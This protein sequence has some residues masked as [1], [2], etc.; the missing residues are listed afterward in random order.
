M[1]KS[2][3]LL[4]CFRRPGA[5]A[6]AQLDALSQSQAV[7]EFLPDGTI[8]HANEY[9]LNAMGYDLQDLVGRHHSILVTPLERASA[10]YQAF[11]RRL[12]KGN[13]DSGQ[14]K[15]IG[16]D[17]REVWIQ[18]TYN[19]IIDR[20]GRVAR[21]VKYGADIT[22]EKMRQADMEGQIAAI[23][24]SQAVIEFSLDGIILY[25]NE[26]FLQAMGYEYDE[27]VGRH[28]SMFVEAGERESAD[29]KEFW[30]KL[31]AGNFDANV[32]RRV[33]KNAREV[34][35][36][37]TYNP[38]LDMNG[39]PFKVVKYATD[40]TRQVQSTQTLA[41]VVQEMAQV[42]Q[43][44]ATQANE[45]HGLTREAADSADLGG[46]NVAAL[47]KRMTE[48]TEA[49]SRISEITTLLD[50]IAFQT[51][52]LALN[53]AIEAARAGQAGRGF[54]VVAGEVRALA[55]RSAESAKAIATLISD[56]VEQISSGEAQ[57]RSVGETMQQLTTSVQAV[58][59]LMTQ[60]ADSA[61]AQTEGVATVH[62][63]I[64][65]LEHKR[66]K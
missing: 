51:N 32:Y 34:W 5:P 42:V 41:R 7:I 8:V 12:G 60:I 16:K 48:L 66:S 64:K 22:G 40:I 4:N 46:A 30:R 53:A 63:A 37:A 17:G 45:A 59:T 62:A 18:A 6:A 44:N 38:I 26:S 29:Y 33:G 24:K 36:Q 49:S 55:H 25:A 11:W 39:R 3:K 27:I 19:P 2:L 23:S 50:S 57:A 28:H 54:S 56:S 58:R 61:Q 43:V 52:L 1:L 35:I 21:V 47:M 15:R 65:E 10:D 9:F 31:R 14:Y 13:F 20:R